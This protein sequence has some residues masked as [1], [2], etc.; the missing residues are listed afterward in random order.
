[1]T[2][3]AAEIKKTAVFRL[4]FFKAYS[5]SGCDWNNLLEK[6]SAGLNYLN[7]E[8]EDAGKDQAEGR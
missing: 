7:T 4:L 6:A 2:V 3:N 8:Q 5:L 1:M